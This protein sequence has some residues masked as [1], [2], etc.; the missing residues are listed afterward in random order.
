MVL[1][2][3][4]NLRAG[5]DNT[6]RQRPKARQPSERVRTYVRSVLAC[7]R[8]RPKAL[9]PSSVMRLASRSSSTSWLGLRIIRAD[10]ASA[11]V[12][13]SLFLR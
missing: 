8:A 3:T 9:A 5:T 2:L 13:E 6:S 1:Y 10:S 4:F 12:A 11:P 7:G